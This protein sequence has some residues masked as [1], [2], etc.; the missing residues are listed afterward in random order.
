MEW[1]GLWY[2]GKREEMVDGLCELDMIAEDRPLTED[3]R[4][5]K[6]DIYLKSWRGVSFLKKWAGDKI[7]GPV[8]WERKINILNF[9]I[10]W[11]ICIE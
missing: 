1:R 7:Q 2:V 11:Q 9:F 4:L 3:E 10:A 8:G 6:E 5:R